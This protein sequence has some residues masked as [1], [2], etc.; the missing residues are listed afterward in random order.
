ME[1]S[2][3][4]I[5]ALVVV[6]VV[7]AV[8]LWLALRRRRTTALRDKFGEEY[9]RTLGATRNRSKAE[10]DLEARAKRVAALDI[11]A[12]SPQERSTFTAEWHEVKAVFVDSPP[13]AV[14][15]AD[16]MLA[17]MMA[18]RGYPMADFD[19]RFEDLSVD[20]ADEARHYRAGHDLAER[21]MRGQAT[22]EDLRQAMKHYEALFDHLVNDVSDTVQQ[23]PI[24]RPTQSA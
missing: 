15:H 20:H 5:L 13:E 4:L 24:T 16:R 3:I 8:V 6:A 17:K 7:A 18:A 1:K 22:T 21:S 23:R 11:R 9:D 2:E 10:A 12:L 14:L 19:R